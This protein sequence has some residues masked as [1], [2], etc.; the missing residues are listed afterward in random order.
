MPY[1]GIDFGTSNSVVAN[2]HYGQAEVVPNQ[3]GQPWTPS[4]VTLRRDGTLA[5]GQEAKENFDETRSIRSIKRILGTAERVPLVGQMLRAEQ[6]AVMLFSLLKKDAE[7]RLKEPFS[8]AVV[9]IPANSKGLARHATKLCAGSAGLHVLT[10]INEPTAAAICYGL[11]AQEEQTVLVYDFGGGTL[12][13]TILKLHHGVFEEISSKG[14]GKLGGDDLDMALAEVLAKRFEE[15]TGFDI[16]HSPYRQP[17]M[18]AVEQAKID[19]STER[20]TVARKAEL[21]PVRHLSLEEE[22]DRQTFEQAIMPLIVQSGTAIDEALRLCAMTPRDIDRVLLVGGT[23]KI[24]LVQRFVSEKL[25][26]KRPEPFTHVDPMTCVAQGAAIVSAILQ[27]APGLDH[28]AYSVKLEHSLCANP[29]NERREVYLDPIIRRGSDIPCSFTKTYYPVADPAERVIISV[30]EGDNYDHPESPDNVKLAEI[31]WEFNPPRSQRDGALEV[32]YEYGDDGILTVTIYDALTRQSK[33][34][35]IQQAG[36]DQLNAQ[37]VMKM[38]RINEEMLERTQELES[39]PEYRDA[40]EVLHKTE[41]EVIPKVEN[42]RER[43]QLRELCRQVRVAMGSGDKKRMAE[44]A[45]ALNDQLLNY[46]YLL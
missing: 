30:Y 6:I 4:I 3:E 2:F 44:A 23:S 46:A 12:D 37:Q 34:F 22:I 19:L 35:A 7:A 43:E 1:I 27:G 8:K 21:V 41:Q 33:K 28:Y 9:T 20:T 36:E 10:L 29:I 45:A 40:L 14:I 39:T 18:L 38:K 15:K 5:F 26:G 42:L 11:N 32:T 31:P 16:L 13:V 24:P 17:F 25:A